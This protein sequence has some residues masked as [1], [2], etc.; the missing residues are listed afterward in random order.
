MYR[1]KK[2]K[3]NTDE[4]TEKKVVSI[5]EQRGYEEAVLVGEG[6]FAQVYRVRER[7]EG[8]FYACKV[9]SHT[10]MLFREGQRMQQISHP[11]F[12]KFQDAWQ[13]DGL[14]FLLMEFIPGCSLWD[15][16]DRRGT[17]SERRAICIAME[18]A[19]GLSY[20][21]ELQEPVYYL[22][23]KPENI[24]IKENGSV[25]LSDLGSTATAEEALHILT[26]TPPYAAPEQLQ[27]NREIG[28]YSDVYALGKVIQRMLGGG[29][30]GDRHCHRGV[31]SLIQ[32]CIREKPGE[33]IP[34]MRRLAQ[35]LSPY[36][37]GRKRKAVLPDMKSLFHKGKSSGYIFLKNIIKL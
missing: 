34:D 6:A 15:L 1:H 16:L 30:S 25:K 14:Y 2:H 13:E 20:L 33:R 27:P 23:L 24:L 36:D 35:R 4:K 3:K 7:G 12:P 17:L 28:P 19:E 26:G 32:E 37:G 5:L 29:R 11:L 31:R 8:C 22:D 10:E 9:S 18:L 21:H